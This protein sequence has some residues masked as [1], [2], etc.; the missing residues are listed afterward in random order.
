MRVSKMQVDPKLVAKLAKMNYGPHLPLNMRRVES[1]EATFIGAMFP[2]YRVTRGLAGEVV[3]HEDGKIVFVT[4]AY[5][6]YTGDLEIKGLAG[7]GP[8]ARGT[9]ERLA[10]AA[11][12]LK[13]EVRS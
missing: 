5:N 8:R 9:V 10:R 12:G 7:L 3:F 6:T 1:T 13:Q 11:L 4:A 2:E